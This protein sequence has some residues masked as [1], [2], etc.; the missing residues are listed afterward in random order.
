[1]APRLKPVFRVVRF[2]AVSGTTEELAVTSDAQAALDAA[3][4]AKRGPGE[5]VIV[6]AGCAD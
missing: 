3:G 6:E 2:H 1:M 4:A 5:L